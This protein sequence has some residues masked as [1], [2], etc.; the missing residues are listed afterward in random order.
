[1][2]NS[3]TDIGWNVLVWLINAVEFAALTLPILG[4]VLAAVLI[5]KPQF[6]QRRLGPSGM[7]ARSRKHVEELPAASSQLSSETPQD[8]TKGVLLPV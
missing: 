5:A 4:L 2:L 3:A 7:T 8:P 6:R 1:M